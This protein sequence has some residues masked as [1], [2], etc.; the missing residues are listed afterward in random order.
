MVE[1][2]ADH[3][4]IKARDPLVNAI[5]F[6]NLKKFDET[7][8]HSIPE[9]DPTSPTF[10]SGKRTYSNSGNQETICMEPNNKR[11][12]INENPISPVTTMN[13]TPDFIIPANM[14]MQQYEVIPAL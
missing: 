8:K 7:L 14:P 4:E 1:S 10:L 3:E 13:S 6:Q 11:Q 5:T 12:K 2:L 9:R